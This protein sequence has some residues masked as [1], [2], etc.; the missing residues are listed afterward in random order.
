MRRVGGDYAPSIPVREVENRMMLA[1]DQLTFFSL[2]LHGT[3]AEVIVRER[4]EGP[5]LRPEGEPS[6]VVA[7]ADGI[8]TTSSPGR[9]MPQVHGGGRRC[10]RGMCSSPG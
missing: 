4:E 1:M 2:N 3:R 7:A 9:G 6:D 8:I 10:A 5:D